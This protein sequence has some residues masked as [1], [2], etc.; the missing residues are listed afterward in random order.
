MTMAADTL[1]LVTADHS[2]TLTIAGY[3]VRGNPILGK[4]RMPSFDGKPSANLARG[5]DAKPYTTLSYANGSG[6]AWRSDLQGPGPK[7]YPH[8]PARLESTHA[9]RADLE[10]IDTEHPDYMQDSLVPLSD[11]THGGEDVAVYARGPGAA[12]V[13]GSIEQ[14]VLFHLMVQGHAVLRDTLCGL[15]SCNADGIPANLPDYA[16]LPRQGK[17]VDR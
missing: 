8:E 15:G 7:R 4:V 3:P 1:I 17:P 10:A 13:R 5:L 11:E 14:N 9:G 16:R 2:H 12:A 6:G